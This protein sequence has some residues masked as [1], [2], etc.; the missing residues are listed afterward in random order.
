MGHNEDVVSAWG[1]ICDVPH[2]IGEE[3]PG[4]I[5]VETPLNQ[6][7]S[8]DEVESR[9]MLFSGLEF[10][11]HHKCLCKLFLGGT[12]RKLPVD[13]TLYP[14][15]LVQL[16]L[17]ETHLEEDPMGILGRL[18]NLRILK[19]FERTYVGTK[20]NCHRG[21][22][23]R[24]EFPQMQQLWSLED[25]SVEEGAMPNLKTL[26]IEWSQYEEVPTWIIAV[27]KAPTSKPL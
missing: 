25:L 3:V 10:L 2:R 17:S 12:I 1:G 21:E 24:L 19:L 15:N 13:I 7:T 23:L 22:F 5:Y 26:K 4:A 16:K 14:P 20:T 27:E 18:P 8:N 11:S 6:S 9:T